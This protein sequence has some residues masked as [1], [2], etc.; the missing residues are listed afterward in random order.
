[1]DAIYSIIKANKHNKKLIRTFI[2]TVLILNNV[3][4]GATI[5]NIQD[6]KTQKILLELLPKLNIVWNFQH[7]SLNIH[8]K[9]K[10]KDSMTVKQYGKFLGLHCA[11]DNLYND[12]FSKVPRYAFRVIEKSTNILILADVCSTKEK[13]LVKTIKHYQDF[14]NKGNKALS[15]FNMSIYITI[16]NMDTKAIVTL[17]T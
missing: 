17:F 3:R 4:P 12:N 9:L 14:I 16:Q 10:Y 2:N 5:E 11:T 7:K 8:K 1:M 15:P 13:D 6:K